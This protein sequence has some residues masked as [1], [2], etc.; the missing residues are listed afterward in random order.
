MKAESEIDENKENQAPIRNS[1][2]NKS[3]D[4]RVK[5]EDQDLMS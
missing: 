4:K 1:Q 3:M 2:I 5:I